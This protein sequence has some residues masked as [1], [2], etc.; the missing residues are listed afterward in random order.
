M[1]L[2]GDLVMSTAGVPSGKISSNKDKLDAI[3]VSAD[4]T[5]YYS[6]ENSV[7]ALQGTTSTRVSGTKS[8]QKMDVLATNAHSVY[9][10]SIDGNVFKINGDSVSA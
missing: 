4:G 1:N 9:A 7:F 3:T 8:S 6:S 10:C 5:V 2:S